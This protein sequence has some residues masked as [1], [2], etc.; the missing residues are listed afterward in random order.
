MN[1]NAG[2]WLL[3]IAAL[4]GA[5]AVPAPAGEPAPP[6]PDAPAVSDAY[7]AMWD[8]PAVRDRI[9]EGIR[10]HRMADAVLALPSAKPGTEVRVE[11]TGHAFLFGGNLFLLGDCGSEEKNRRYEAVFG[12]LLNAATVPLYWRDLEPEPGRPRFAANSPRIYRRPPP[13]AVVAFCESKGLSMNGHTLVWNFRRWSIPDWITPQTSREECARLIEKRIREIAERYGRR[14]QRWDV[15]NESQRN[16]PDVPMPDDYVFR[17]LKL[18]GELLPPTATLM[19][20][21]YQWGAPYAEQVLKLLERGARID[22]IGVQFHLFDTKVP[23]Q[24]ARGGRAHSPEAFFTGLDRLARLERPIHM[25]EITIPEPVPGEAGREIQ[26][27]LAVNW[28]RLWFSH[29]AVNSIT[30]WNVADGGAAPGE[31][32]VSGLL[33]K[34][35]RPKAVYHALDALI[36]RAWKTRLTAKAE[37][38]KPV[39]FHGFKGRYRVTWTD[40]NGA[41]KNAAF[42][43]RKNGDGL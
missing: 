20:N 41:E 39:T 13:D 7:R 5:T 22:T 6:S 25:S 34:E 40:A 3:G 30:W 32:G 11:Q 16:V 35:M 1:R 2:L 26:A 38:G 31:P 24:V 33:D 8:D 17:S 9:E 21:D 19:I 23:L 27:A 4:A 37:A 10:E 29:P 36:N 42:E 15:V 14:I 12:D 43:L 28:Y 18:A